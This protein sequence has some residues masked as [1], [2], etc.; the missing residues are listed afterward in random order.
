[1]KPFRLFHFDIKTLGNY[2]DTLLF[3]AV[4]HLFHGYNDRSSFRFQGSTN[5]RDVVGPKL[6]SAL[7]ENYD[8][9]VIGGG[10]LF[11]ADTNPNERSGW[12]WNCSLELLEKIDIPIIVFAVG[13][14]RFPGQKDFSPKFVEHIN[15][16]AEKS[17]FFGL[18]NRGSVETIKEYLRPELR[19]KVVYQPCPT[20]L[21]SYLFPDIHVSRREP[22]RELSIQALVGKRQ[23]AAGFDKEAIYDQCF[24][25]LNGLRSKGW[26]ISSFSNARGDNAFSVEMREA[27]RSEEHH[28]LFGSRNIFQ[29]LDFF[30]QTPLVVGMRGHAQMI[31]FGLGTPI[32]SLLVHN[33]L[34]YFLDDIGFP[35]FCVD[36]RRANFAGELIDKAEYVYENYDAVTAGFE[37]ARARLMQLSMSNLGDI[38]KALGGRG[39]TKKFVP[40]SPFERYLSQQGYNAKLQLEELKRA[41]EAPVREP[42]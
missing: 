10:G 16:L 19:D 33:K 20:T 18:R 26:K 34:K 17:I 23:T 1:M 40:M 28:K 37:Q 3:E 22:K 5:L 25:A 14:N 39:Q 2:G 35:E 27:L 11:L 32:L 30:A 24:E 8:A 6:V 21:S 38:Y 4:R 31:P 36:V 13:N 12:Q 29:A 42:A 7:N 41:E 9:V 15:L